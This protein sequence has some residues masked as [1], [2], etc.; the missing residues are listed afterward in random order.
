MTD[1]TE[2][3]A[4]APLSSPA[5]IPTAWPAWRWVVIGLWFVWAVLLFGGLLL[6]EPA[7][8]PL[9]RMPT[10]ARIGSSAVLVIAGWVIFYGALTTSAATFAALVAIGMTLG[11]LGDMFNANLI[12]VGLPDPVLGGIAAFG[13]GH[14]A[15][16]AACVDAGRRTALDRSAPRRAAVIIWLVIGLIGWIFAAYLGGERPALRWPALPYALLLAATAGMTTALALA[17]GRFTAMALGA[18]LFL[19]SDLLLAARLFHGDFDYGG[20]FVWLMYGPGQ[21]GIVYGAYAVINIVAGGDERPFGG[22]S[23]RRPSAAS[24]LD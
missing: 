11:M 19:A 7:G 4:A 16:I 3:S 5:S 6:G 18:A 23:P 1:P 13:L 20:D 14:V 9:N 8:T 24:G 17:K 21:M 10:E 2:H 15:Y 12:S 22:Q